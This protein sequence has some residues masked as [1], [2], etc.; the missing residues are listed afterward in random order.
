MR[1]LRHGASAIL[2]GRATLTRSRSD[3]KPPH[4]KR[5]IRSVENY[6]P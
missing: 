5:N 3:V 4:V 1:I 6:R 2:T